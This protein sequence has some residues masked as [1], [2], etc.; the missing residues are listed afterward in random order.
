ME[1]NEF[2]EELVKFMSE[3]YPD[4]QFRIND[5]VKNNGLHLTGIAGVSPGKNAG[6]NIYINELY[7]QVADGQMTL[8]AAATIVEQRYLMASK[9]VFNIEEDIFN[10]EEVK[11][12][13][14][15][16]L[17]NKKLNNELLENVPHK[18]V[19]NDLAITYRYL[20][21]K[22]AN[23]IASAMITNK[24]FENW[25]KSL[26]ELHTV[27]L[28]NTERLF[29][30]KMNSL[31]STVKDI[32][33]EGLLPEDDLLKQEINDEIE[34]YEGQD[35]QLYVLT[36]DVGLNG[37]TAILYPSVQEA[38]EKRF[39][40]DVYILPCSI[41]ETMVAINCDDEEFLLGMVKT[42]NQEAVRMEDYLADSI[43]QVKDGEL[44]NVNQFEVEIEE[45]LE[46]SYGEITDEFDA[47]M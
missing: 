18:V 33:F 24:E 40:E 23:G 15:C 46:E 7:E 16:R 26:D 34:L 17:V 41:H 29:P 19:G 9:E 20:H 22:D 42:A 25:G 1:F 10:Y 30:A 11:D 47:E 5:I 8:G 13:L 37:A 31:L 28:A 3:R 38:I 12:K 43:Y 35:V 2:K 6:P 21:A 4:V 32:L 45:V 44:I 14:I 39:G 36:N 27:A